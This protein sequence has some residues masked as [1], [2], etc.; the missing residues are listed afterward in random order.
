VNVD[1]FGVCHGPHA[2]ARALLTEH[3][4]G[5]L[6]IMVHNENGLIEIVSINTL[7]PNPEGVNILSNESF[8]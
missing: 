7:A 6:E 1:Q 5:H 2:Q 8:H 3:G 4:F